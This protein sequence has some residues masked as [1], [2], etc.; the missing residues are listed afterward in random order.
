MTS[1]ETAEEIVAQIRVVTLKTLKERRGQL[2]LKALLRFVCAE[3]LIKEE[4]KN[5]HFYCRN[6]MD[7]I[8]LSLK[9]ATN[10]LSDVLRHLDPAWGEMLG[11]TEVENVFVKQLESL[12]DRTGAYFTSRLIAGAAEILLEHAVPQIDSVLSMENPPGDEEGLREIMRKIPDL[13][14]SERCI[15]ALG[16]S[17]ADIVEELKVA[18]EFSHLDDIS[19][20]TIRRCRDH[21]RSS[22]QE[23]YVSERAE[24]VTTV[25]EDNKETG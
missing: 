8:T 16:I 4:E 15:S 12:F 22:M 13:F 21:L 11:T 6:F 25:R 3:E 1:K 18:C 10:Q 19:V 5:V 23:T 24:I 17:S 14:T 7:N 9:G 2:E 20:P